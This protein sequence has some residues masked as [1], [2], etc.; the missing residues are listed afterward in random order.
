MAHKLTRR[1][2]ARYAAGQLA[3]GGDDKATFHRL[4]QW[5]IDA[6][7]IRSAELLIADIKHYLAE[8]H[9]IVYAEVVTAH[10]LEAG[11][12]RDIEALLKVDDKTQ[13][14][15]E[16]VKDDAIIGGVIVRTSESELDA[17]IARRIKNMKVLAQG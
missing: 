1:Q 4:A 12:Q 14:K 17:S 2:V 5:L 6:K 15:I 9:N 10:G 11:M 16:N 8:E 13:V 7:M 3:E